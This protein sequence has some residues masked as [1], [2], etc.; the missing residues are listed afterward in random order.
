MSWKAVILSKELFQSP[1]R[2]SHKASISPR[3]IISFGKQFTIF[4]EKS[5]HWRFWSSYWIF[6]QENTTWIVF[7]GH[8]DSVSKTI[9]RHGDVIKWKL[10]Q[11]IHW[12][13][14]NSPHKGQWRGA[15][16]FSLIC[17]WI[18]GW[19]NNREAADLRRYRAHYDV[20]IMTGWGRVLAYE[21]SE[22]FG[23]DL[24]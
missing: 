20:T 19:V 18:H 14:V 15:L 13:P 3:N 10:L 11:G 21:K 9:T 17:A 4:Q 7:W 23:L 6:Q 24:E 2:L 5:S 12:S 8:R 1:H 16:M 22:N